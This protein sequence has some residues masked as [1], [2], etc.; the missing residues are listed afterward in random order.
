MKYELKVVR[1]MEEKATLMGRHTILTVVIAALVVIGILIIAS[2]CGEKWHEQFK[3]S[4]RSGVENGEPADLIR[5]PDGFNNAGTK[6]DHGNRLYIS[7]HGDGPYA[8]IAVVPNDPTCVVL[9][10]IK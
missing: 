7:Y 8:A 6:C 9:G 4:P 1:V 3:D 2:G 5:M 10:T